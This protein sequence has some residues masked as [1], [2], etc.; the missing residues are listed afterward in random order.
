M[1]AH[2]RQHSLSRLPRAGQDLHGLR[3][4]PVQ[5]VA[6]CAYGRARRSTEGLNQDMTNVVRLL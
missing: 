6:G 4:G 3:R 5:Q 2:C 1:V